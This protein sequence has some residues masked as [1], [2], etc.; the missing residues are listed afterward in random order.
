MNQAICKNFPL[1]TPQLTNMWNISSEVWFVKDKKLR[2][3]YANRKF[4]KVNKLPRNFDVIGCTDRELPTSVNH[5]THLFEEHDRKVLQCMKRISAIGISSSGK[6]QRL[7]YYYCSKFPFMDEY[8]QFVGI[9]SHV[10]EIDDFK[11]DH[12]IKNNKYISSS[13]RLSNNI[14]TEREL[15]VIFLFCRGVNNKSIADEMKCSVR[16]VENYFKIIYEKL[17]IGSVIELRRLCKENGYDTY[18]PPR[19]FQSEGYF[20]L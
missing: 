11:V 15:A 6:G 2:F 19:Y 17:G 5:L 13:F 9:I 3:I 12:Y 1:I 14:L 16:T 18:I 10:R 7:K 8:N 4:F 20:L